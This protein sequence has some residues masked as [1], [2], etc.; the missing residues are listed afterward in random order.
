M[1]RNL[2]PLMTCLGTR[3]SLSSRN[4]LAEEQCRCVI[5]WGRIFFFLHGLVRTLRKNLLLPHWGFFFFFRCIGLIG[6]ESFA[7]S[8]GILQVYLIHRGYFGEESFA[9]SLGKNLLLP[10]WWKSLLLP[11]P[12]TGESFDDFVPHWGNLEMFLLFFERREFFFLLFMTKLHI[13]QQ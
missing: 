5:H 12:L 10:H 6:E 13:V 11:L 8:Q 2:L 9:S 3:N 1:E 4:G 7:S